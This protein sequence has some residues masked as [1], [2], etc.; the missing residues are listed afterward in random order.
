[1]V[2]ASVTLF[3]LVLTALDWTV[4]YAGI[5]MNVL[6]LATLIFLPRL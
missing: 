3:S 2:L 5:V 1:M 4:A 6:I